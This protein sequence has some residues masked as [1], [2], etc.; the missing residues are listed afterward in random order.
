MEMK[1]GNLKETLYIYFKFLIYAIC[2]RQ[3]ISN[4][5]FSFHIKMF[6]FIRTKYLL[7]RK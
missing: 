4:P 2:T 7:K 5:Q 6:S 3:H 1:S